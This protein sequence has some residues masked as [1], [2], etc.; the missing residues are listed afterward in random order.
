MSVRMFS[1]NYAISE[2]PE[3]LKKDANAVIRNISSQYTINSQNDMEISEKKVISILNSPGEKYS[4][5]Y[6]PYDKSRKVSDI[7]IKVYN[8]FGKQIKT[9]SKSDL[10]DIGQSDDSALYTDDRALYLKISN[11]LYPYTLDVQFTTNTSNTIFLPTLTP[12]YDYNVSI[13]NREIGILNK[14]GIKLRKKNIENSFAKADFS[15]DENNLKVSYKNIPA[16]KEEKYAPS[17][18]VV[19]PRCEFALDQFNLE[20]KKG[21]F[22]SWE[23]F[24]KWYNTLLEPVS[25]ITPEIQQEVNVLN[26]QGSTEEKVKKI[27]QYMQ[28]KTRY[29]NVAI[30]IGG[31]QPMSADNVRKKGYGDCK[32]LTNYMRVLL[33]AAGIPSYYSIIYMDETS[34]IFDKD[35]P[36]M[37]GNHVVLC[38]PTEKGNIWLENTSQKIAFDH[39]GY[40]TLD[41]NVMMVKDNTV[42]IVETPK[43]ASEKSKEIIRVKANLAENNT[44]DV[45]SKFSYQGNAYDVMMPLLYMTPV[46]A[47]DAMK[48]RYDN[49]QFKNLNLENLNNDKDKANIDFDFNFKAENYSKSLGSDMYFRAIPFL[50]SDFYLESSD[51]KFPVEIPFGFT[52]DYEIEYTIPQNYKFSELAAP[53]KI[54]SEF[55]NYSLEFIIKDSKLVVKRKFMLKKGTFSSDKISQYIQF[56]KQTNKIDNTKILITKL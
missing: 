5:V 3:E 6:I 7:K 37:D 24:G 34:K 20:G 12:F 8:E 30:G 14:S 21:N 39:L 9:Y 1:Q 27:Y 56:R 48:H 11:T 4:Y 52:D 45:L 49:L 22:T 33:K 2:I 23:E 16:I 19:M 15:G 53:V 17:M 55:G 40:R 29:V 26:L 31:W 28:S 36:K 35:F 47:N 25:Q 54:D 42:E 50:E 18:S 38:V 44:L 41:R 32:A 51:R 10:N 46:E 13:E 43:T